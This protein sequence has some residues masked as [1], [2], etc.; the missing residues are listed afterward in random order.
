MKKF[1]KS[2]TLIEVLISVFVLAVGI[3]AAI[4][5]IAQA[6]STATYAKD[7]LIVSY[8]AK[9]GIEI[10]KNIRDSNWIRGIN[11]SQGLN[12][13]SDSQADYRQYSLSSWAGTPLNLNSAIG[14]IYGSGT[15][16]KFSR[17][18]RVNQISANELEITVQV[19]WQNRVFETKSRITN[20]LQ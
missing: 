10:V 14:Y 4:G 3:V 2:F 11:W 19:F 8:L 1:Q 16:T 15:P 20:W 13:G 6:I 7:K 12:L 5:S 18:I 9:E 17:K